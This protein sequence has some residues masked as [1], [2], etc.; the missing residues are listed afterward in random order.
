MRKNGIRPK[1]IGQISNSQGESC[2]L[3]WPPSESFSNLVFCSYV[4]IYKYVYTFL[5]AS[6]SSQQLALFSLNGTWLC[7]LHVF[8]LFFA[9][10]LRK[11]TL[12]HLASN[13]SEF[14]SLCAI[15]L[16][17]QLLATCGWLIWVPQSRLFFF[18][19]PCK[20]AVS[21]RS[22]LLL[23]LY[24]KRLSSQ[25]LSHYLFTPIDSTI[26]SAPYLSL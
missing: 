19:Y 25:W 5:N 6:P 26:S 3:N 20:C 4:T 8:L 16:T 23:R 21:A 15:N 9:E 1:L 2:I 17:T 18:Y 7:V 10:C 12:R 24:G 13:M 14:L 22:T 11:H